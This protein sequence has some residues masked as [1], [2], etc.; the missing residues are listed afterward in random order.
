MDHGAERIHDIIL[1]F[2][3]GHLCR[4]IYYIKHILVSV[5]IALDVFFKDDRQQCHTVRLQYM[6]LRLANEMV[7]W[8]YRVFDFIRY[9]HSP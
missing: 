7:T 2:R 6:Q 8:L 5:F 9:F 3:N 1:L 4:C